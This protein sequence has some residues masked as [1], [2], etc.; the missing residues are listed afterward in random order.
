MHTESGE[1]KHINFW[2][3]NK[4]AEIL[5]TLKQLRDINY[6]YEPKNTFHLDLVNSFRGLKKK[7]NKY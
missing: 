3:F 4:F 2:K 5:Y 1:K 7:I 6:E